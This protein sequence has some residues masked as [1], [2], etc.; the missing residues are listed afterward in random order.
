M[1]I[2][3]YQGIS[4]MQPLNSPGL[5]PHHNNNFL[6]DKILL[7]PANKNQPLTAVQRTT[8]EKLIVKIMA[9]SPAKSAEIWASLRHQLVISNGAELISSHFQSAEQLLQTRLTQAQESHSNRQLLQQLTELLPQGN[10]RLLV[11]NFMRQKFGHTVLNQLSHQQLQQILVAL[12]SG[13]LFIP[14]IQRTATTMRFL[15]PA[16]HKHLQLLVAKMNTITGDQPAK[17]WQNL[18]DLMGIKNNSQLQAQYFQLISQFLQAKIAASQQQ[19]PHTLMNL[20]TMLK[21]PANKQ[22]Q[23]LLIDYCLSRF[24]ASPSTP[25]TLSQLNNIIDLLFANRFG[26]KIFRKGI[27]NMPDIFIQ[28]LIHLSMCYQSHGNLF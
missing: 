15:L 1:T 13:E 22:E 20:Q 8:L 3:Y 7:I 17:I 14:P 18:F 10:N 25:L 23:Q 4:G 12:Q 27:M 21:S 28:Y 11:S 9:I 26:K 6:S 2:F 16:E 24:Q 5:L 19:A